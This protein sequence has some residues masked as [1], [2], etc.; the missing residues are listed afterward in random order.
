MAAAAPGLFAQA[1]DRSKPPAVG[2]ARSLKLP[3]IQHFKLS[4]G[5]QVILMEKHEVPLV[6]M[7]M[8]ALA[9]AAADPPG[10]SGLAGM[11]VAMM[12]EGA[13]AR[14]ALE[15][16]DAIDFLGASISTFAGQ[17]TAA[18]VMHTPLSKLDSALALFGDMVQRPQFPPDELERNRR[19]RLTNLMQWHDDPDQVASVEFQRTIFGPEHPY[20]RPTL[21]NEKSLRAMTV[22]DLRNF[23]KKYFRP[24]NAGLLV[25]G[26]LTGNSILPKLEQVFGKWEKGEPAQ[27]SF[28]PASQVAER[29]VILV[30]KPGAP[31]SV[32]RI[33]RVGAQR[34]TED[35]FPLVV[36][37]TILG[38]SFTSRLNQNLREQ[39]GYT[40]GAGSGFDFLP[41]PGAF[42]AAAAVQTNVTDKAL[43]EFMKELKGILEPVTDE[44]LSRAE[45]YLVLRYPENFQSVSQIAGQ[46]LDIFLYRLP[47]DYFNDYTSHIRAVSKDD[48]LRVARK[49]LDP[50]KVA[51]VVVGDRKQIEQGITALGLGPVRNLTIDDVLGPA[52][53]LQGKN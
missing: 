22:T 44:E 17:H 25:V 19:D 45:N 51:V 35:Y 28:P 36:M 20:G 24:N 14:N 13:G 33:G 11:T 26:D 40:Y 50:A 47:D 31:Q 4:N 43:V 1:P 5:L 34:L 12:E 3:S 9:G 32:I 37:N 38:G 6:Q 23:H 48:V 49:Y 18:V 53:V 15:L 46:L 10:L 16:A 30:D 8:I 52:P 21:G 27:I 42:R 39:H 2:P 41:T 29:E 7:E